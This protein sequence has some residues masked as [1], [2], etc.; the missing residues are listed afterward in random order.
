MISCQ[1]AYLT[2]R[3]ELA[4]YCQQLIAGQAENRHWLTHVFW[5]NAWC[6]TDGRPQYLFYQPES[7]R[8]C[9]VQGFSACRQLAVETIDKYKRLQVTSNWVLPL[10]QYAS[11][12]QWFAELSAKNRKRLRWLR[13]ALPKQKVEIVPLDNEEKFRRFESLFDAQFPRNQLGSDSSRSLWR[14]Y[15]ELIAMGKNFS[16]LML[17]A[18][19]EAVAAS[20]GFCQGQACNFTHLTRKPGLLDKYSPGLYLVYWMIEQLYALPQRPAYFFLGPGTYDYKPAFLAVPLPV[21]RYE[22]NSWRNVFGLLR[23][24]NRCRREENKTKAQREKT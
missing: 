24:Y 6:D 18:D 16:W 13:N 2:G 3:A 9:N 5:E 8:R 20:L 11:A 12:E 23:L 14:I 21:Y 10:H 4:L 22:L 15:Q 17:D 7:W 1:D 19:G